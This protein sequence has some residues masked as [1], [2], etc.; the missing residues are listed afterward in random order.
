[1]K[2][3]AI[4]VSRRAGGARKEI[5]AGRKDFQIFRKDFQVFPEGFPGSPE[6]FPNA[7]LIK[8]TYISD[9]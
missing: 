4:S 7:L 2:I 1:V 3:L 6:G 9:S 5:Q 8:Y